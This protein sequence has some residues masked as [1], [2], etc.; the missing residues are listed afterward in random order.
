MYDL[1]AGENI[2]SFIIGLSISLVL[3]GVIVLQGYTYYQN[4]SDDNPLLKTLAG[5]ILWV[6]LLLILGVLA[7][8][9]VIPGGYWKRP[10]RSS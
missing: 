5:T 2:G 10:T 9:T 7:M 6:T 3:F 8:L 1:L 4:F